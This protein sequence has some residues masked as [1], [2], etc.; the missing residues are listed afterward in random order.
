MARAFTA[1]DVVQSASAELDATTTPGVAFP[2]PAAEGHTGVIFMG[3]QSII[4]PPEQWHLFG[5]GV[6]GVTLGIMLR[7]DLSA[8]EQAWTFTPVAGTPRWTWL[9]EEWANVS[10]APLAAAAGSNNGV[11]A[12]ASH[13]A[14]TTGTTSAPHVA[15][16]AAVQ[17]LSTGGTTWPSVAWSNGFTETDVLQ[18][19]TGAANADLQLRVARKYVSGDAG[20]FETTATFTG[21]MTAKTVNGVIVPLRAENYVGEA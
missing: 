1:A 16:V 17:L 20:P 9:A 15:V 2:S 12:P 19:G 11:L 8:G 21:D 14:G 7:A 3:A 5:A 13:S 6:G 10:Y 4:T 18:F